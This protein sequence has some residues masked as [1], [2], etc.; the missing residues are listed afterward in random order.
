M[1]S[2]IVPTPRNFLTCKVCKKIYN[3]LGSHSGC[4]KS[5]CWICNITFSSNIENQVHAKKSHPNF[6]CIHCKECIQNLK[7]HLEPS[8]KKVYCKS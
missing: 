5:Y 4:F 7:S 2:T 1:F 3:K 8:N 6:Y